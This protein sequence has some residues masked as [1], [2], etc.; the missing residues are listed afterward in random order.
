VHLDFETQQRTIK[1]SGRFYADVIANRGVTGAA[2]ERYVAGR[3]YVTN[4]GRS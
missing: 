2:Y 3:K 4:G 1:E